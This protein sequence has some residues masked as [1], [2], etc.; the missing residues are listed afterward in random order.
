MRH[1]INIKNVTKIIAFSK[2]SIIELIPVRYKLLHT[3]LSYDA[4]IYNKIRILYWL[5]S[6]YLKMRTEKKIFI[7]DAVCEIERFS[8]IVVCRN[9]TNNSP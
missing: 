6:Q 5:N 8:E 1:R 4:S 3:E 7:V 2:L 9:R